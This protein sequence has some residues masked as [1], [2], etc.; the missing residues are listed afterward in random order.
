MRYKKRLLLRCLSVI[1]ALLLSPVTTAT[2]AAE[3]PTSTPAPRL[4]LTISAGEWPPFL[5]AGLPQQGVIAHLIT[6]IFAEAGYDVTFHFIPW[7]RAYKST[8]N[9]EYAATAVWMHQADREIDFL[10][11]E[12]VLN[13]QFVFF[14]LKHNGFDWQTLT[15]LAGQTI[16]GVHAYSYGP[17]VDRALEDGVFRMLRVNSTEQSLRMLAAERIDVFAEEMRIGYHTLHNNTP[18]I[19]ERITHHP[20]PFLTNQS[21]LLF[22]KQAAQSDELRALFNQHLAIFKADGRY[23]AYFQ[24]LEDGEYRSMPALMR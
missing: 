23:S 10:Y 21:Y 17:D 22:P 9:T 8:A 6:D 12:P 4:P 18:E 15:D 16:G 19:A 24:R 7:A 5:S 11:S 1:A 2:L 3:T 13:E 20:K 14:H